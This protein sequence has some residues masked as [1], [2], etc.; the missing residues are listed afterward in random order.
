MNKSSAFF[1]AGIGLLCLPAVIFGLSLKQAQESMLYNNLDIVVAY[2]DYCK[3]SF[4][5]AEAKAVWWPSLD[6]V[7]SYNYFS[8]KNSITFSSDIPGIPPNLAGKTM[9]MGNKYRAEAGLDVSYPLT[10]ALVNIYNVRYRH[11]A[12]QMKDTQ[13]AGLK[14]QLSF[15]LGALYFLWSLSFSQVEVYQTLIEQLTDQAAQAQNLKTGGLASSSKVLDALARLASAKADLVTAQNQ[16]DSLKYEF[17][18]FT[19]CKDSALAPE[20]YSFAM[21]SAALTALDTV[22]LNSSRPELAAMDLGVSQLSVLQDIIRGQKYPNLVAVAGYRYANPGLK[23]GSDGFMG[24]GQAGLQLKWNLFDGFRVT[25]QR[26]Q[27]AQQAEIV[28]F[29]KQQQI[30]TW[31]NAIKNARLQLTRA[32]RQQDAAQASFTAAEAVTADAKNSMAAGVITQSDYLNALT[33]RARAAL[34]VK[35]AAFLKNM[36]ILQL[37]F[38]SGRELKF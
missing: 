20:G 13:N 12:L 7:G 4:E 8:E 16:S 36:A 31:N 30:D 21:D 27:A 23:M 32:V 33:A 14:N 25:N 29:Q 35:Q 3:K 18:N 1:V 24:Y 28:K 17:V 5:E 2:Q 26:K 15:K 19:Q 11:L 38:A 34:A 22:S 10:A 9:P 37:Y 6:M